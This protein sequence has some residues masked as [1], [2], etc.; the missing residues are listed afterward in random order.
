MY[1]VVRLHLG[2]EPQY[3]L[4]TPPVKDTQIFI[5]SYLKIQEMAIR[6]NSPRH[7]FKN[8]TLNRTA[9]TTSPA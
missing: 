3:S 7:G 9:F 6:E 8:H 2:H 5:V 4:H 1:G